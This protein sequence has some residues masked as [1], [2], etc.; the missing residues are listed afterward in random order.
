M[1]GHVITKFSQMC[2]LPDFLTHGA[3]RCVSRARA[4]LLG[5]LVNFVFYFK[6]TISVKTT[7]KRTT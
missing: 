4:P 6:F 3:P 1:Y 7:A 2:S 5:L